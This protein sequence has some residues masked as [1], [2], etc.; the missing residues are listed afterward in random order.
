MFTLS[1]EQSLERKVTF[2]GGVSNHICDF[3]RYGGNWIV[4][5]FFLPSSIDI[6]IEFVTVGQK[7]GRFVKVD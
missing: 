2:F 6:D 5:N 3:L 7:K 1:Q 4:F